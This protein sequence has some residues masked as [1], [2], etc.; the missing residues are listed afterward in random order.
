MAYIYNAALICES[1]GDIQIEYL[2]DSGIAD[3]GDSETFPQGPYS[4]GGGES[5]TPQHCDQCVV[6]LE[7]SLTPDGVEYVTQA[8][9]SADG[10]AD[11][12]TV[13]SEFYGIGS[14]TEEIV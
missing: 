13:W 12:L 4:G 10:D 7:N 9:N 11:V 14:D 8:V 6:F 2:T 5:D 3:D 1:C